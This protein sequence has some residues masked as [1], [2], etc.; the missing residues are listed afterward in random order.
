M[1]PDCQMCSVLLILVEATNIQHLW[2]AEFFH[3]GDPV[4]ILELKKEY[5]Q[6]GGGKES[7]TCHFPPN[8]FSFHAQLSLH[9]NH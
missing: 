5:L 3:M 4:L 9:N 1:K 8:N 2:N 7:F 6:V